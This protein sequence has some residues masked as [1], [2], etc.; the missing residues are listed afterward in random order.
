MAENINIGTKINST[1][2]GQL[3]T[4]NDTIEKYCYDNLESNCDIYGGHY[5]WDEAM[6]YVTTEGAQGICMDG[7]YLP[8][9]AEWKILEGTV[10]SFYPVGDL[11]WDNTG[12]R[13]SD[14]GGNMKEPGTTH[15]SSPNIGATNSS[16]FTALPAG[17]RDPDTGVFGGLTYNTGFRTSTEFDGS[18]AWHRALDVNHALVNRNN[19]NKIQ[20]M[21]VRCLKNQ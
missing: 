5:E 11:E 12:D 7:W 19:S 6:G 14:A 10:D 13:G 3:Q 8:T 1:T 2:G 9:D 16:K 4:D 15:W 21:P 20:G 17:Y 18:N